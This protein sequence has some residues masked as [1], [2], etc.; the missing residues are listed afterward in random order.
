MDSYHF[1]SIPTLDRVIERAEVGD[2]LGD[3]SHLEIYTVYPTHPAHEYVHFVQMS[4]E[5]MTR[6]LCVLKKQEFP[7]G[8][9][10]GMS[11]YGFDLTFRIEMQD[12][13]D[14]ALKQT[15]PYALYAPIDHQ[16]KKGRHDTMAFA[17]KPWLTYILRMGFVHL[18]ETH[19]RQIHRHG[20]DAAEL[21]K[22]VRDSCAHGGIV[23]TRTLKKPACFRGI[24]FTKAQNGKSE[25]AEQFGFGDYLVL[26]LCMF[27]A[28]SIRLPAFTTG[29]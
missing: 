23:S 6:S 17:L 14:M 12:A 19:Q 28:P 2:T 8:G 13:I 18:Y 10:F 29:S 3:S 4:V 11:A 24:E 20:G 1:L 22:V 16:T 27:D 25:L 21:A 15:P 9:H 7:S 26:A 5:A